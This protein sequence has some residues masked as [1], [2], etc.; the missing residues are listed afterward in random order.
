MPC[1]SPHFRGGQISLQAVS[2]RKL[3]LK[4]Q[5]QKYSTEHEALH[6]LQSL[7]SCPHHPANIPEKVALWKLLCFALR[8]AFCTLNKSPSTTH[9]LICPFLIEAWFFSCVIMNSIQLNRACKT[10]IPSGSLL[11]LINH[12][13]FALVVHAITAAQQD[14]NPVRYSWL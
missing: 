14:Y 6:F 12:L 5:N 2:I 4:W 3:Q 7:N 9:I 13:G 1:S 11:T 10:V 8:N